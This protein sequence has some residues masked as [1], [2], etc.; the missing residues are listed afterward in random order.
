MGH[1]TFSDYKYFYE[2]NGIKEEVFSFTAYR[3]NYSRMPLHAANLSY[4]RLFSSFVSI[5]KSELG[6][7][8]T[9]LED[10]L[11]YSFIVICKKHMESRL[12]INMLCASEELSGF[13]EIMGELISKIHPETRYTSGKTDGYFQRKI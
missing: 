1:I 6:D 3:E 2:H 8:L 12:P 5:L 7:D 4:E 13:G 9:D 10:A 11:L